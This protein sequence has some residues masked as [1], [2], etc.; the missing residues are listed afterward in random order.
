MKSPSKNI[1]ASLRGQ[2]PP[3]RGAETP[4]VGRQKSYGPSMTIP[5]EG[6]TEMS[7]GTA[8]AGDGRQERSAAKYAGASGKHFGGG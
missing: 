2:R 8:T 4:A 3:G 7:Q 1:S 6:G 5:G